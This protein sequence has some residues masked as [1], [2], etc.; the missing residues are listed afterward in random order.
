VSTGVRRM[1]VRD[2]VLPALVG[3]WAH[4]RDREQRIRVNIDL[5]IAEGSGP[6]HDELAEV[7]SYDEIVARV[8]TV[9]AEGHVR[10]IETL[11]E[12]FAER[13][14]DDPRVRSVRVR[15]EK[16]DVLPE[17]ES[18]GIEIERLRS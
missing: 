2:L 14:L 17:A 7:V 4:E 5:S 18:V 3:V 11:A 1:F 10:L 6:L 13:C 9:I 12:R 15:I 8:R 16:L